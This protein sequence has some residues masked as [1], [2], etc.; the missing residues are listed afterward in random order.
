MARHSTS[1]RVCFQ[2]RDKLHGQS[3]N[4]KTGEGAQGKEGHPPEQQPMVCSC[5]VGAQEGWVNKND[6]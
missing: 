6:N 2:I 3:K 1:A 5:P 4:D